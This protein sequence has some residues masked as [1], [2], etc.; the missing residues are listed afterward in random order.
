MIGECTSPSDEWPGDEQWGTT[1]FIDSYKSPLKME[2]AFY[3][4]GDDQCSGD[5]DYVQEMP[6]K[7]CIG[8]WGKPRPWGS[9]EYSE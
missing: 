7:Q 1:S 5:V 2:R 6:M 3:K 9:L 4:D 8:P